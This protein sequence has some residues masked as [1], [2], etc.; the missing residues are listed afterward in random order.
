MSK[1][2]KSIT[3]ETIF[4]KYTLGEVLGEGGS[5]RVYGGIGPDP[6]GGAIAVKI[7]SQDRA[8]DQKRRRFMNE[9][10]FLQ[11]NTHRNIVTVLDHGISAVPGIQGPF[12]VMKRYDCSL[13]SLIN[14]GVP[15]KQVMPWFNQILNGVEAAHLKEVIHRDL[16][17]ENILYDRPT[18]TIAVA[19]FG[20]AR[21]TEEFLVAKVKTTRADRL[22]NFQ[23]AAPEQRTEG[24]AVGAPADIYAL[25]LLLNEMFTGEVPHGTDYRTIGAVAKEMLFLDE[26]VT[27]MRKQQPHERPASIAEVKTLI[28]RSEYEAVSMQRLSAMSQTV[29]KAGEIDDP[30]AYEPPKLVNFEWEHG[31]LTLILDRNISNGWIEALHRMDSTSSV[32]GKGPEAFHFQGNRATVSAQD[33]Q[34][35]SIINHFKGWLPAATQKLKYLLEQAILKEQRERKERLRLEKEAEERRLRLLREIKI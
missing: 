29:V 17:P 11:R 4:G 16:K 31:K 34:V 19:D 12:Y 14:S 8:T 35:Q 33:F 2:N 6:D 27:R 9:V 22:A 13:R 32:L 3:V 25:G 1:L 24:K 15:S 18:D 28:Q 7:L 26:I 5:G 30:L 20:I 10:N 23:Y 21:F